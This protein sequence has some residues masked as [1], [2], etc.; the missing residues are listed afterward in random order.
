VIRVE[1]KVPRRMKV[2]RRRR[3]KEERADRVAHGCYWKED[4]SGSNDTRD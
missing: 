1:P 2:G 4:E 3:L